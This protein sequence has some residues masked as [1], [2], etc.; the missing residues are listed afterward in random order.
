MEAEGHGN[1]QHICPCVSPNSQMQN[2]IPN[3]VEND[4]FCET[5]TTRSPS[6]NRFY[7]PSDPLWNGSG[8]SG[9]NTCCTFN[10]PPWFCKELPASTTDDIEVRICADQSAPDEDSP[11]YLIELYVK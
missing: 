2:Y 7:T 9:R 4:Y 5:G 3:F 11:I 1:N 8:C 6:V 10:N